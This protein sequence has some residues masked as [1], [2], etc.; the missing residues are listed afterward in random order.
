M[1]PQQ[2]EFVNNSASLD[3]PGDNFWIFDLSIGYRFPKRVGSIKL[4]VNNIFNN[5]FCYQST[6]DASGP[7]LSA[8]NPDRRI[9][10][11]VNLSF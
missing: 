2:A 4:S 6:F 9:F 11:N 1:L 10:L 3:N 8:Y 5:G 7:Q